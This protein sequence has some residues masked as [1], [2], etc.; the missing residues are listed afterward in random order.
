M[1]T[2]LKDA[3]YG[4]RSLLKQP[5]FTAIAV[6]TL[7]LGIAGTTVI[8]SAVNSLLVKPLAFPEL[9]RVVAIWEARPSQGVER[10]EVTM[11]DYLDW[12]KQN[13]TF[14]QM[15]LYRWWSANLTG[16]EPP[17]RIQ[18]FLV[19][20]NFLDVTGLKPFLGRAFSAE[21]DQ[22]GKD[23]VIILSYGLWQRRFGGDANIVNQAVSLNGVKRTIIG[24]LPREFNYT[25]GMEVMAVLPRSP[26]RS[27]RE[28]PPPWE[29]AG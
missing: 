11:A 19:S 7:A 29:L 14:E 25:S 24:V 17:E 15:G 6:I 28:A 20:T 13:E 5:A 12:R 8:F 3:R 23:A 27:A 9:H 16:V 21:E 2:L 4:I 18:G 10:N 1:E 26:M 22:P